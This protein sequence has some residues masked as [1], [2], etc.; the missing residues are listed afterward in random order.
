MVDKPERKV[1]VYNADGSLADLSDHNLI[2][3]HVKIEG[4]F[5]TEEELEDSRRRCHEFMKGFKSRY[6]GDNEELRR[7][8][9][10]DD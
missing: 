10:F 1:T 8:S 3:K 6:I 9:G 7:Q 2:G 5:L 4:P